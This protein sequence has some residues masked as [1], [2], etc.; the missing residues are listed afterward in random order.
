MEIT[1]DGVTYHCNWSQC[2]WS[3]AEANVYLP[4]KVL[5]FLPWKRHVW[6]TSNGFGWG[7]AL[8]THVEKAHKDRMIE[9]YKNAIKEYLNHK[10]S[11]SK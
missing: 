11:W 10:K 5:G 2:G 4:I 8:L 7:S 3:Y 1:I 6:T 9:W